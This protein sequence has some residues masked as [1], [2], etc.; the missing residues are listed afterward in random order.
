MPRVTVDPALLR[1]VHYPAAILRQ[2]ASEVAA[3]TDE[4]RAVAE[5]M[6]VL[7]HEAPGVGL[8]AP[9][10]GLPW[11]MFVANPTGDPDDN[12]IY[13]NPVLTDPA[14]E[15]ADQEEGCL[16]LPDIR[17]VI[18]RPV[19]IAIRALDLDGGEIEAQSDGLPA[20]IWQH[21]TD[22]LDGVLIIQR[23]TAVDRMA[24][25]RALKSLESDFVER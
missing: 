21:E 15:L 13:V 16:S 23:M 5:R 11:R 7:M 25:R 17:G 20:R 10:V 18:R 4:V 2:R 8:A 14:R 6:L 19:S 12:A 22:H 9:Q 24:N 1:I 3:V